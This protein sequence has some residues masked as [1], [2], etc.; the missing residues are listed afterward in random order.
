MRVHS[1]LLD[2]SHR[3]SVMRF[4]ASDD[5]IMLSD[6]ITVMR[7]TCLSNKGPTHMRTILQWKNVFSVL[8]S[9]CRISMQM[10][11]HWVQSATCFV[12]W[13]PVLTCWDQSPVTG[14][15]GNVSTSHTSQTFIIRTSSDNTHSCVGKQCQP[16]SWRRHDMGTFSA[17]LV[18]CLGNPPVTVM[19]RGNAP[20]TE[21]IFSQRINNVFC[22][23]NSKQTVE[24]VIS[25][26][27][28]YSN[29]LTCI[30]FAVTNKALPVKGLA[31]DPINKLIFL[32]F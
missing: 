20:I 18:L 19:M 6:R 14:L 30:P 12:S 11:L 8:T 5:I 22:V 23:V 1:R 32:Q 28:N 29:Q 26:R 24:W 17:L 31:K 16:N 4:F 7:M 10:Y 3:V 13:H 15:M 9:L 2:S 25:F 27:A 21:G